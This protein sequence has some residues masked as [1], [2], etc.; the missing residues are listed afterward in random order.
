MKTKKTDP[1]RPVPS[2]PV[3]T[4]SVHSE[5]TLKQEL[6]DLTPAEESQART[7]AEFDQAFDAGYR[8]AAE[9]DHK[10]QEIKRLKAAAAKWS[11]KAKSAKADAL[12]FPAGSQERINALRSH[13]FFAEKADDAKQRAAELTAKFQRQHAGNASGRAAYR[14]DA[15]EA[16]EKFAAGKR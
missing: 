13:L 16:A 10:Q 6:Q 14:E 9:L 15:A 2:D 12:V 3:Q 7:S 8:A 11:A 1:V 4:E 5:I